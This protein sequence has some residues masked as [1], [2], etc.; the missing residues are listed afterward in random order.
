M[1]DHTW[2]KTGYVCTPLAFYLNLN[3]MLNLNMDIVMGYY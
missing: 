3:F 1:W 2:T